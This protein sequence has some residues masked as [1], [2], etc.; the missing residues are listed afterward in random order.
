MHTDLIM[1]SPSGSSVTL[2]GMREGVGDS[3]CDEITEQMR[4]KSA[5]SSVW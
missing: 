3:D 1:T 2:V 4:E 5:K